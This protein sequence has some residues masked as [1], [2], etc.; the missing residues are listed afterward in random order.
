MSS[1]DPLAAAPKPMQPSG[2][3][4]KG[5]GSAQTDGVAHADEDEE[6]IVDSQPDPVLDTAIDAHQ[7]ELADLSRELGGLVPQ[8]PTISYCTV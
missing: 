5:L 6:V 1:Y 3:S 4:G 7:Q 2:L 8:D